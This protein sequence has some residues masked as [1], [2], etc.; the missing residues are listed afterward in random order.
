[1]ATLQDADAFV[2]PS[3]FEGLS[4][5]LLEALYV[6]LPILVTDQVELHQEIQQ[7]GAGLVVPVEIEAIGW[8]LGQLAEPA[9]RRAM[10][11]RGTELIKQ[12]YTW[13]VIAWNLV[14]DIQN[15]LSG[16]FARI[17]NRE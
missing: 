1:M 13:D 9:T 17:T 2:L 6:G 15:R 14:T 16:Q 10:Q 11:G 8:G 7:I 4:I 3:R 12:K 5:A